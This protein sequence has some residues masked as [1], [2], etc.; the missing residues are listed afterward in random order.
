MYPHERSLVKKLKDKPFALLGVDV[1]DAPE[2]LK[3]LTANN[4]ITWRFWV[5]PKSEPNVRKYQIDGYPMLF[6]IDHKGI[7]REV[8]L[9]DPEIIN[10]LVEQL[11]HEIEEGKTTS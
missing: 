8:G 5:E 2:L 1:G 4:T 6:L 3:K 10:L 7:I 11:L 9:R